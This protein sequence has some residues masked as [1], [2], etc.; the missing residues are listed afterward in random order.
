[1]QQ[2]A[3][4]LAQPEQLKMVDQKSAEENQQPA[5]PEEA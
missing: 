2:A 1:V 3:D 5:E 4:D